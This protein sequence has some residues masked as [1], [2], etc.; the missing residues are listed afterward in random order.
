M[1][2]GFLVRLQMREAAFSVLAP[3]NQQPDALAY[4][5]PG[6]STLLSLADSFAAQ[7]CA[8]RRHG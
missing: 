4:N 5:A 7:L 1:H 3:S 8:C 6:T 2:V